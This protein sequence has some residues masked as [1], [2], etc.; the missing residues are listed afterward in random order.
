MKA[1]RGV[2]WLTVLAT[3]WLAGCASMQSHHETAT[4][5]QA[6]GQ[7][8]DFKTALTRLD[9]RHASPEAR[10]ELLYNLEKGEL[11][12]LDGQIEP[13]TEAFLAAGVGGFLVGSLTGSPEPASATEAV[14]AA[15]ATTTVFRPG[16]ARVSTASVIDRLPASS[17]RLCGR[18][19]RDARRRRRSRK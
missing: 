11:L 17:R 19:N 5:M 8:G 10:K 1:K 15:D 13:S 7:Q 6:A 18:L 3:V 14:P 12:R 9:E 16:S 4:Q 2:T